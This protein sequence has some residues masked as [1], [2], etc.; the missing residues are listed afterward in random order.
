MRRSQRK[1]IDKAKIAKKCRKLGPFLDGY[2]AFSFGLP[3]TDCP[4]KVLHPDFKPWTEGWKWGR[5]KEEQRH[6]GM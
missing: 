6:A 1:A 4:V 3:I 5:L 2:K